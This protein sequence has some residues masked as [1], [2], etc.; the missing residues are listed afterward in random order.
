[1][2]HIDRLA[3]VIAGTAI[4]GGVIAFAP[5][6]GELDPPA[7]PVSDTT[8]SLAE[9]GDNLA[10]IRSSGLLM[11]R[12]VLYLEPASSGQNSI[13]IT[14]GPTL[15][16]SIAMFGGDL[17]VFDGPGEITGAGLTVSGTPIGRC[18]TESQ[19][20]RDT[21]TGKAAEGRSSASASLGVVATGGLHV[22]WNR[23]YGNTFIAVYYTELQ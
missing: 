15:V 16:H 17:V 8:P 3:Y 1:M 12:E 23:D 18:T 2:K 21:G 4:A 5:I 19:I 22:A 9:I 11:E 14:Q 7:G 6:S 20:V 10:E 13:E